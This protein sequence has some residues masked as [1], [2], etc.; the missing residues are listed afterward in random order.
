MSF[1]ADCRRRLPIGLPETYFRNC[2][3]IYYVPIKRSDVVSDEGV[4]RA[5]E[6]IQRKVDELESSGD[7]GDG[8]RLGFRAP[9]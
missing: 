7:S 4:A 3:G 6:A 1:I 5:A 9:S 8:G 2:L